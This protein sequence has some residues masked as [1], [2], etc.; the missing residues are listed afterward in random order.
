MHDK[1]KDCNL[2]YLCYI[3]CP[4]GFFGQNCTGECNDT[5]TGCNNINGLCDRGCHRG[6]MGDNC[7]I[8]RLLHTACV[9]VVNIKKTVSVFHSH[10]IYQFVKDILSYFYSNSSHLKI[11]YTEFIFRNNVSN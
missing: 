11:I 1:K 10:N 7:D 2:I 3:A 6:W 5:C 4:Y 9:F 8:G